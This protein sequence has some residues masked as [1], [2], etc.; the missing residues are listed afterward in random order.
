M[1]QSNLKLILPAASNRAHLEQRLCQERDS[2]A[3]T[4]APHFLHFC[5]VITKSSFTNIMCV[6]RRETKDLSSGRVSSEHV[7]LLLNQRS[8]HIGGFS[9]KFIECQIA[10]CSRWDA[11]QFL[12]S[13]SNQT[14]W[15]AARIISLGPVDSRYE[16]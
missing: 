6:L 8:A 9:Q 12:S 2:R 1:I 14:S 5:A 15:L 16:F 7:N 3:R 4:R 13:A 11:W 10:P